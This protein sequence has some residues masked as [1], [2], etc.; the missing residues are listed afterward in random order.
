MCNE[1]IQSYHQGPSRDLNS[2]CHTQIKPPSGSMSR[3]VSKVHALR[4]PENIKYILTK[5]GECSSISA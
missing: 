1:H 5:P 2:P 3:V 4:R